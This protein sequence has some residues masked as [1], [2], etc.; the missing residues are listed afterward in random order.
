VLGLLS[1]VEEQCAAG[2]ATGTI[3]HQMRDKWLIAT[4]EEIDRLCV[5]MAVDD[6]GKL[7]ARIEIVIRDL[8]GFILESDLHALEGA[9]K[10]AFAWIVQDKNALLPKRRSHS[11]LQ[12]AVSREHIYMPVV[13]CVADGYFEVVHF[14]DTNDLDELYGKGIREPRYEERAK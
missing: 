11:R 10:F 2:T 12:A 1:R 8:V 7:G 6:K 3:D 13:T 9:P 5:R 4:R 14:R